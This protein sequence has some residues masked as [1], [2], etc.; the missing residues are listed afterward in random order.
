[1]KQLSLRKFEMHHMR[2]RRFNYTT[3]VCNL[4]SGCWCSRH[5]FLF[6]LTY[7]NSKEWALE[8]YESVTTEK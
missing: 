5:F 8:N 7:N 2:A 6:A 3:F 1:M 4:F